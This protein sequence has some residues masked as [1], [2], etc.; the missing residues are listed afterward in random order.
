[1]LYALYA[2]LSASNAL[3]PYS[4]VPLPIKRTHAHKK[5]NCN[6]TDI[7]HMHNPQPSKHTGSSIHTHLLHLACKLPSKGVAAEK[8]SGL[9]MEAFNCL[10]SARAQ[11]NAAKSCTCNVCVCVCV[12]V[13]GEGGG[14]VGRCGA[15]MTVQKFSISRHCKHSTK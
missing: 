11:G 4:C 5:C 15:H 2:V 9:V 6:H 8:N 10:L 7:I 14:W 13:E 3:P 12:C 1:M